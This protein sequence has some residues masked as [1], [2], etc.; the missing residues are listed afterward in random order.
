MIKRANQKKKKG[1]SLIELIIVL[2]VMAIIALIAI[3][4]FTAVRENSKIK[5]DA[6]SAEAIS[7]TVEAL[8]VDDSIV[9]AAG[10]TQGTIIIDMENTPVTAANITLSDIIPGSN[11]IFKPQSGTEE[12]PVFDGTIQEYL[13]STLS[14]QKGPQE[15]GKTRYE[16]TV[17]IANAGTPS[18]AVTV[19]AKT[20]QKKSS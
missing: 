18:Q 4:N 6:Q 1:F 2:A 11:S 15:K 12:S 10:K 17:E 7:R 14:G 19:K 16:V 9:L 5:A 3:P 13:A 8:V 20:L